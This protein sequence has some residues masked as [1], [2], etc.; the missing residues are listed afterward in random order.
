[1]CDA[2]TPNQSWIGMMVGPRGAVGGA[3]WDDRGVMR[4]YDPTTGV[5]IFWGNELEVS[6]VVAEAQR[7][8]T[9]TKPGSTE[10]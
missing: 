3:A 7:V 10:K 1:V 5:L 9:I 4:W 8:L 6:S 2:Q